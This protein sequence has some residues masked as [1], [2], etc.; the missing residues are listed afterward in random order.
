[1][2]KIY[3]YA[4]GSEE[5]EAALNARNDLIILD[6]VTAEI[7]L[8]LPRRSRDG[9]LRAEIVKHAHGAALSYVESGTAGVLNP[10]RPRTGKPIESSFP[11][12]TF[13]SEQPMH[14]TWL[15]RHGQ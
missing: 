15:W 6:L 7:I 14:C 11:P 4:P 3:L 5:F 10:I 1:L 12:R 2:A 13:L 8:A 9:S